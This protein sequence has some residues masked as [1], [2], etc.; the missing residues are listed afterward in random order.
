MLGG[1][2]IFGYALQIV[3]TPVSLENNT[4]DLLRFS[5]CC[6]CAMITMTTVGFG[7]YYPRSFPGRII[8]VLNTLYG[9]IVTSLMVNFVAGKLN[10]TFNEVKAF[11]ATN[12]FEAMKTIRSKASEIISKIGQFFLLKKQPERAPERSEILMSLI[13]E[14]SELKDYKSRYKNIQDMNLEEDAERS[15][16][17]VAREVELMTKTMKKLKESFKTYQE[18]LKSSTEI[19]SENPIE[20][21]SENP[22]ETQPETTSPTSLTS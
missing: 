2:A 7:D 5:D 9:M 15:F 21:L 20:N 6:W 3:E 12:R 22:S 19:P 14:T 13:D 8:S 16:A 10:L 4:I 1:I 17:L 18:K 11:T